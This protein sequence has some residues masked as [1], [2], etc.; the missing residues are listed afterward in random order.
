[1]HWLPRSTRMCSRNL[2][3]AFRWP[4]SLTLV[5]SSWLEDRRTSELDSHYQTIVLGILD[6]NILSMA[7]IRTWSF[8][9]M[10]YWVS[11]MCWHGNG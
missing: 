1:M 5:S 10:S 3:I 9:Y 2:F 6:F 4:S 7:C 11:Q 8:C